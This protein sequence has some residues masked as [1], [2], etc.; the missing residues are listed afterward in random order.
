MEFLLNTVKHHKV[1]GDDFN[2][3]GLSLARMRSSRV[4]NKGA[5]TMILELRYI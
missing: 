3:G 4:G 2:V 1:V 5:R